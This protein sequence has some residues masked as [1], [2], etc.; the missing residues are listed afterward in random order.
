M[1]AFPV[2]QC[3]DA[4]PHMNPEEI[5]EN[6]VQHITHPVLWTS[7]T[8]N[9]AEDGVI[10]FY[11]VGTDDTLEKIV[12]RMYPSLHVQSLLDVPSYFGKIHNYKIF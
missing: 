5:K 10:E 2:Y 3:V 7:M 4:L 1:P 12:K 8:D 11:E 9:M 6:L